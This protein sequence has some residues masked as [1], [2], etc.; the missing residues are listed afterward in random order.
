VLEYTVDGSQLFAVA[1]IPMADVLAPTEGDTITIITCGGT[2]SAGDYTH[3][4]VVK[5]TRTN[6]RTPG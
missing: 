4:L 3:R 2:F 5:G 6:V 1:T